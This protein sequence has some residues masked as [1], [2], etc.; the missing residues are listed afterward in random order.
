MEVFVNKFLVL[1]FA[2]L[3]AIS[4]NNESFAAKKKSAKKAKS[5]SS[6]T[7]KAK[8]KPAKKINTT[9]KTTQEVEEISEE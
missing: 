4:Y 6:K 2:V 1:L 5:T 3:V 7:Y 8:N 9:K